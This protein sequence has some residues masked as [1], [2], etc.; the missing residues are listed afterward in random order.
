MKLKNEITLKLSVYMDCTDSDDK[1]RLYCMPETIAQ[2]IADEITDEK[3][4]ITFE[5][6]YKVADVS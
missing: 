6:E 4:V 2:L 1:I 3:T 5:H